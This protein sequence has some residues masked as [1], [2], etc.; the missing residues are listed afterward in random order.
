MCKLLGYE[1]PIPKHMETCIITYFNSSAAPSPRPSHVGTYTLW[2]MEN[3][4]KLTVGV[5]INAGP[6]HQPWCLRSRYTGS[7]VVTVNRSI[8]L[9]TRLLA[10]L[11]GS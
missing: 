9:P 8:S 1:K 10:L 5:D 4:G 11:W 7:E 2:V 3:D 6:N